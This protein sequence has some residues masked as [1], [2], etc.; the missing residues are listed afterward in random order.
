MYQ[1]LRRQEHCTVTAG[2]A[3]MAT[4][5][6]ASAQWPARTRV[7]QHVRGGAYAPLRNSRP[8]LPMLIIGQILLCI[9]CLCKYSRSLLR[10]VNRR[11]S[12]ENTEHWGWGDGSA[13][14]ALTYHV[15]MKTG[16][17]SSA[18]T[19]FRP[20]VE[21]C[22][23]RHPHKCWPSVEVCLYFSIRAAQMGSGAS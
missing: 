11:D 19:K 21:A 1:A 4:L 12:S 22:P 8:K 13:D 14:E 10:K 5:R 6:L 7:H 17:C 20:R 2:T 23:G 15:P 16:V 18:P 9:G 3:C